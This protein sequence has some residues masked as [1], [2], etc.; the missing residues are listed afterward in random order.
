LFL[1]AKQTTPNQSNR[2]SIVQVI[3]PP[4]VFPEYTINYSLKKFYSKGPWNEMLKEWKAKIALSGK[5][6]KQKK[7]F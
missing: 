2:R 3:L 1:F 5:K 6:K 7:T 4:F